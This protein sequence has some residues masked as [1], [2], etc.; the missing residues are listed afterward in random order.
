MTDRMMVM[1][2]GHIVERGRTVEVF[3][4]LLHPYSRG[5]FE[6]VPKEIASLGGERPRLAVIPGTVQGPLDRPPGCP[7]A[8]RCPRVQADCRERMP[9][10][11]RR[12]GSH[13]CACFHPHD[14]PPAP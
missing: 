8:P 4:G 2:A 1:Y 11:E 6:A 7:F 10:L 3:D 13:A 9:P 5:L 14:M 12:R